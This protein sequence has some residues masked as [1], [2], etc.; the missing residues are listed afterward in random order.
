MGYVEN[1]GDINKDGISEIIVVPIWFIGCWGRMEFYTFKEG[2]WHNF[3]EAEC[4]ICN[5]D[6]YRYI[7]RITKLSKNK[8]RVIEDAWDS[9]AGDRVKKPKILRLNF[10]KQASNSK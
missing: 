3:G 8:I 6:D 7:E 10:K 1:I 4:H 5:E 2:K 9:E